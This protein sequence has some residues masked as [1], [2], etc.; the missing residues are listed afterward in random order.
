M[1]WGGDERRR[2]ERV[3]EVVEG[4]AEGLGRVR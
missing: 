4:G 1:L 3:G 2:G